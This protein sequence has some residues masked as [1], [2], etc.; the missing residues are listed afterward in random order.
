MHSTTAPAI[1]DND[2]LIY[3][4]D[5]CTDV[6]VTDRG[7]RN[8]VTKGKFPAPD[9]NL[10]GRNFWRHSTYQRWRADVLAGRFSQRRRPGEPPV[11]AATSI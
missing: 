8:W 11:P 9:G 3:T 10:N 1:A 2:R 5:I 7:L 6:G 4:S